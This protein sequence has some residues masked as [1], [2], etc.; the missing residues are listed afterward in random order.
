MIDLHSHIL[1]GVD[2]GAENLQ[3]AIAMIKQLQESGFKQIVATPHALETYG[4]IGLTAEQIAVAVERLQCQTEQAG[5]NVKILPGAETYIFPEMGKELDAGRLQ[6]I[7][8]GKYLLL[9][10][11]AR[12]IPQYT[13]QVFFDLQVRGITPILAH[14]ERYPLLLADD[15]EK[16]RL[17]EW[18]ESGVLFQLDIRSLGGRYGQGPEKNAHKLLKGNFIHFVGSDIHRPSIQP[19]GLVRELELL[20]QLVGDEKFIELT[21]HN[22]KA[23]LENKEIVTGPYCISEKGD[24]TRKAGIRDFI[25]RFLHRDAIPPLIK[26]ESAKRTG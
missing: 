4:E 1:P 17:F 8:G 16:K 2:D 18:A 5:L 7:G 14:P 26:A 25:R 24:R 23:V 3:E 12:D 13:E 21:E 6:T 22:P 10:L 20:S 9:E 15:R 11:P 19:E